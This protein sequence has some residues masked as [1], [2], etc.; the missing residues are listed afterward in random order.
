MAAKLRALE[1]HVSQLE[2]THFYRLEP[3]ADRAEALQGFRR[4]QR[5]KMETVAGLAEVPG[6]VAAESF[7]LIVDQI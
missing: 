7:H 5:S 6:V 1:A 2:T 3:G 4:R